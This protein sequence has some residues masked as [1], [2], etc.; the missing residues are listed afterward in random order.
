MTEADG[1]RA[2]RGPR[3]S[4][5][6]GN[7]RGMR[8]V[9]AL[10]FISAGCS[11][12]L[13][14]DDT[15]YA[16]KDAPTDAP[17]V[18][19]GAPACVDSGT[20]RSLCGQLVETGE[21]AGTPLRVAAPTGAACPV[22]STEG[23]CALD[24]YALPAQSLFD[25]D[26]VGRVDGAVDDCGRFVVADVDAGLDDV[27][28]V[29]EGAGHRRVA[30]LVLDRPVVTGA[31]RDITGLAVTDL[32]AMAWASQLNPAAPPPFTRAFLIRYERAG[33]PRSGMQVAKD[34][35][36]PMTNAVGTSPW[37]RYTTGAA[38]FGAFD[39]THT[40]TQ[41]AGT[42]IAVIDS[43]SDVRIEG[44]RTGQRC[45]VSG[46]RPVSDALIFVTIEC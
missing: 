19:D 35:E 39:P 17:S 4:L 30:T 23:P 7:P 32:T 33:M 10:A 40:S 20:G 11:Q 3:A 29:V 16:P 41:D 44:V 28:I 37:A 38:P 43:G 2:G 1:S 25:E 24:V 36:S 9:L 13:G 8:A 6:R 27:A 45:G 12:L 34:G 18:C 5:G 15:T 31:D 26:T 22:D 21:R 14:L 46:L 42:A